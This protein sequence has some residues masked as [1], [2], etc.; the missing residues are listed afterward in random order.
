PRPFG[1]GGWPEP[2]WSPPVAPPTQPPKRP[3][4]AAP[5]TMPFLRWTVRVDKW[6]WHYTFT[7]SFKVTWRD[8]FNNM[9]RAGSWQAKDG[10]LISHWVNSTT[11]EEWSWPPDPIGAS[12]L[13]HMGGVDYYLSAVATDYY[14]YP[15]DVVWTG[16]TVVGTDGKV[17]ATI[18][19][20]DEVRTGGT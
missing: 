14:L 20:D 13:C 4:P 10:T 3:A 18:V 9:T 16:M 19:Y 15:G 2:M 7:R 8:P 6:V 11:W 17:Q 12:G 1:R 5:I